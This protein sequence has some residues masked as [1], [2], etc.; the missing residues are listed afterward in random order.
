[1]KRAREGT[2]KDTER[3]REKQSMTGS[4]VAVLKYSHLLNPAEQNEMI[5]ITCVARHELRHAYPK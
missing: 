4:D 5:L 1:M 2:T 3:K